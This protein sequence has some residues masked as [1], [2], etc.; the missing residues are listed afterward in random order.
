MQEVI[1][2][3]AKREHM[4][5]I[6]R[7]VS[8]RM[9]GVK[10]G[11]MDEYNVYFSNKNLSEMMSQVIGKVASEYYTKKLSYEVKNA[12]TDK[13]PDL[14]FTKIKLPMEIKVTSTT[15][16]WTGGEFSRRPFHYFL[17]SW[18]GDFDEFFVCCTKLNKRDWKSNISNRF[19]GPSLNLKKLVAKRDKIVPVG[20]ISE[21]GR[22]VREK[23]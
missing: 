9:K 21:K 7:E 8:R 19:Y 13:E 12:H 5:P 4:L 22:M 10:K 14:Y 3:I 2:R 15:N 17:V 11:V 23:I 6:M 18:G 20:S 1:V 16:A